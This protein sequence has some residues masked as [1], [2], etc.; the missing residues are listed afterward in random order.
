MIQWKEDYRT[1]VDLI[2]DQHKRLLEIAAEAHALLK[3][4]LLTD[5]YDKIVAII[6]ELKEY[7]VYHFRSEEEYMESINYKRLLSQRVEHNEFIEKMNDINL[8]EID[9]G[10]NLYLLGV[11][12]F[13]VDWIENHILKKDKLITAE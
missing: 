13:V 10:Q 4:E 9:N 12:D 1:G 3:D 2:D 6:D 7:T 8:D 5:K 11:L